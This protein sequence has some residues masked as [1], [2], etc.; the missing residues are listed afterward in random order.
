MYY[1]HFTRSKGRPQKKDSAGTTWRDSVCEHPLIAYVELD[2]LNEN[3]TYI[4]DKRRELEN[5]QKSIEAE[6]EIGYKSLET[7]KNN[8]LK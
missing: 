6:W 2:S 4:K 8:F 7:Q 3:I 1:E 5:E